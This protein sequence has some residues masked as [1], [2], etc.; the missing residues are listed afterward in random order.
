MKVQ[1]LYKAILE[2]VGAIV[3][4]DDLISITR[5]EA[6][7]IFATIGDKRLALPS[8]NLLNK[9]AFNSDGGLIAFHPLCE[10]VVL[11]ASPVLQHL[12]KM[13][14]F[15]LTWVF[16]ELLMQL[17]AIAANT[18]LHKKMKVKTHGLLSALPEAD[19]RTRKDFVRILE[20]TTVT[21]Q[22]RLLTLFIRKGGTFG[23]DK[24]NQ[25]GRFYPSIVDNLDKEKRT[26]LGVN[27]RIADVA[28]FLA[29]IE[30]VLPDYQDSDR[31]SAPTNSPVAPAFHALLKTYGKVANQLNKIVDLHEAHL[32]NAD[33]LRINTEWL[34]A[35]QDL[36]QYREKIPMLPGNDGAEGT[37]TV[38][39]QVSK[40]SHTQPPHTGGG[41]TPQ[42][43]GM[44]VDDV[45]RAMTPPAPRYGVFDQRQTNTRYDESLPPWVTQGEPQRHSWDVS[46]RGRGAP[47]RGGRGGGGRL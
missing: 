20:N 10:N 22:K 11:D 19:D 44:T 31:Y 8:D 28:G 14:A 21:G 17:V 34:D 40:P 32:E 29:L 45:I 13:M 35:V 46:D 26:L 5:P 42:K 43:G 16:R 4:D 25:L 27:L 38:K 36:S 3:T 39:P 24:V 15:R 12:E 37:Q 18:K 6:D 23:G 2:A 1:A 33:T 47:P 9:G 41:A 7:P 30:Y